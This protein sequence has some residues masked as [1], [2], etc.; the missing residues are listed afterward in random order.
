MIAFQYTKNPPSL[1]VKRLAHRD[2]STVREDVHSRRIDN[3]A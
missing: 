2:S 1:Q 3:P